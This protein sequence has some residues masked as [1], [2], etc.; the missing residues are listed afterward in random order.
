[1]LEAWLEHVF[2]GRLVGTLVTGDVASR[3]LSCG[4]GSSAPVGA[5]AAAREVK[6]YARG[7]CQEKAY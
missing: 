1:M 5:N 7:I 6:A 4:Q 2:V 3:G